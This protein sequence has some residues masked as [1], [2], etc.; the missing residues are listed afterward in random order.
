MLSKISETR[1]SFDEDL[2]KVN[3]LKSLEELRIKYLSRKGIVPQLFEGFQEVSREE[4]KNVGQALNELKI[5]TQNQY[6]LYKEKL[7]KSLKSSEEPD[8]DISLPGRKIEL[9]SKHLITQTLDEIKE[10]FKGIGFSVYE[11]PELESDYNNFGALNFPDDHP[12]RDMQDTF[13][14]NKNF[15]LRTHTSPVQ[16]RLMQQKKPPIRA[17][18]PGKVFRNEAI[19]AK[20]YC[21]FHQIEGLVVDTDITFAELKGTLVG[22]IK[23]FFGADV[24]YRFRASFFPFTEPSAE[25]DIWW[26]PK[27][28]AGR[29]LEILGCGMVDPNVLINVGIDPEKY[30]GYAFGMG[31]ERP[32]M[33]KYG[34]DDIRILFDSDIRFL[35]QF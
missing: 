4:K 27:G 33:R 10:V 35:R 29:W 11:G 34:I 6:D 32:A 18:M 22:F 24:V 7:E 15:L 8:I 23:Q 5:F 17:L 9:G 31:I 19:S 13:F 12:A 25:M 20:S 21:L 2:S 30:I 26:Q 1:K 3:D 14:I 28:K 16:I